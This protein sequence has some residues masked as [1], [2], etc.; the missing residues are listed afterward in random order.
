VTDGARALHKALTDIFGERALIQ[1]CREH[2]KRYVTEA[3][4]ESGLTRS[5]SKAARVRR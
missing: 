2:K 1:C 5:G 3:L 4:P